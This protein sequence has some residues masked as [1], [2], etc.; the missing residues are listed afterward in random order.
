MEKR[1]IIFT[2]IVSVILVSLFGAPIKNVA[3]ANPLPPPVI[4]VNSPQN[5]QVYPSGEVWLNLTRLPNTEY[6]TL[7]AYSLDGKPERK[8]NGS[9]LLSGLS[10]GSHTLALYANLS[11][12]RQDYGFIITK[13]YF[14]VNYSTSWVVFAGVSST[15]LA[16][17]LSAVFITRHRLMASL[18]RKK[19]SL[20]WFGLCL[21][22]LGILWFA[23]LVGSATFDYLFPVYHSGL[24]VNLTFPSLLFS[25]FLIG[26]GMVLAWRGLKSDGGIE[27]P[28]K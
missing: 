3:N 10:A 5:N 7:V 14:S 27:T 11:E 12:T 16:V 4:I 26:I 23:L 22:S 2:I 28:T 19:T 24:I 20:F 15:V 18:K 8:T 6:V 25:W 17:S 9:E 21:L 13:V 1:V